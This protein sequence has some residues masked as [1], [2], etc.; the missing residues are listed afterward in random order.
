MKLPACVLMIAAF[1]SAPAAAKS[2]DVT[3]LVA[4]DVARASAIAAGFGA[5]TS[6]YRTVEHNRAVGGVVNSYHL[7]GRAIDVVRRA[8]VTHA[9]IAAALHRAGLT[10]IE[11]LD[12]GD[13][14]HFAFGP[15]TEGSQ[16]IA[17]ASPPPPPVPE[18]PK[19]PHILADDH[20]TLRIDIPAANASGR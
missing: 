13:H 15:V 8:G 5:I 2:A 1:V 17:A 7:H 16:Q 10:M 9:Q 19:Y 6:I 18:P 3:S 4:R 20:G 14:S 12:E 11:S